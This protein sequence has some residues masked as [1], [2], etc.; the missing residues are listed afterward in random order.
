MAS[1][2]CPVSQELNSDPESWELTDT[3]GDRSLRIW[4]EILAILD[5]EKNSWKLVDGWDS[6]ISRKVRQS[7][8]TVR[9]VVGW[10]LAKHWLEVRQLSVEGQPEVLRAR[11][12]G[13]YRK[14]AAEASPPPNPPNP[15]NLTYTPIVP[16]G[17]DGFESFW[18]EYPRK[19]GKGAAEKAWKKIKPSKETVE[20]ILTAVSVQKK[21]DQWQKDGGQFIPH[22]AT[23]LN[24]KRWEDELAPTITDES[25]DP[26]WQ[27]LKLPLTQAK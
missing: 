16:K 13:K 2:Y 14:I 17:D 22:P 25:D 6:V 4:I 5:R 26:V 21:S 9:R 12:Y 27:P 19:I 8:A 24:Q 11:N 18:K 7:S 3:F 23:W 15:P 10:M 20:A 1:R